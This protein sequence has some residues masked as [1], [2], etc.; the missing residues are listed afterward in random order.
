MPEISSFMESQYKD[1]NE[2]LTVIKAEYKG[3]Y[4]LSILFSNG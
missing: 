3:D 2:I 4:T 1:N